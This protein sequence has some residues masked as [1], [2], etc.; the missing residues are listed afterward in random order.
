MT[1]SPSDWIHPPLRIG[2]WAGV[3]RWSG[4]SPPGAPIPA[5]AILFSTRQQLNDP[6][7]LGALSEMAGDA[8]AVWGA[9]FAGNPALMLDSTLVSGLAWVGERSAIQEAWV[10]FGSNMTRWA[11]ND[12]PVLLCTEAVTLID[13][14]PLRP[15][16]T[17][18]IWSLV[19][20]FELPDGQAAVVA[21]ENPHSLRK[22]LCPES[23]ARASRGRLLRVAFGDS[24]HSY[25]FREL[26]KLSLADALAEQT[27]AQRS[28][29]SS[30]NPGD[31]LPR[32]L[33]R[34]RDFILAMG[35][36]LTSSPLADS[37]DAPHT[38]AFRAWIEGQA[39]AREMGAPAPSAAAPCPPRSRPRL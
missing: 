14:K 5:Q 16:V 21:L 18:D 26:P 12:H 19:F 17:R 20:A 8:L 27:R 38:G 11:S 34:A 22:A 37:E 29:L 4:A 1:R 9:G 25:S 28:A 32:G 15:R 24:S 31:A 23:D 2:H 35:A 6:E 36:P 33:A 13:E 39:M 3:A 7:F 30:R 10:E